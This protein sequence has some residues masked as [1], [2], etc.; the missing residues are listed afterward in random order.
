S[1]TASCN[2]LQNTLAQAANNA[3][4]PL[5]LPGTTHADR[6]ATAPVMVE[7]PVV[8]IR[9]PV[10]VPQVAGH[11]SPRSDKLHCGRRV[12]GG[13]PRAAPRPSAVEQWPSDDQTAVGRCTDTGTILF[14][15]VV[16][17]TSQLAQL[18]D[19]QWLEV[20]HTHDVA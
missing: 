15:D 18:G 8:R 19:H 2:T 17:S 11:C 6:T 10:R 3:E 1:A 5:C 12:R 9:E 20:L 16:D 14:T 7:G 13:P 4:Q